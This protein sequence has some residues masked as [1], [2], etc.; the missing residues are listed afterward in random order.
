MV[1]EKEKVFLLADERKDKPFG[2]FFLYC[3]ANMGILGLVYGAIVLG[4]KLSFF[5]A[6][7]VTILG[8]FSYGIVGLM[9]LAGKDTGAVTFVLSRASFGFKG[10]LIPAIAALIGHAGWLSINVCTGTL[11]LLALFLT[12]GV[13]ST[14][15]VMGT[16]LAIF[17]GLVLISVFFSHEMLVKIQTWCTYLFGVLTLVILFVI[18]PK[19]NWAV[20]SAMP[21]GDW[22]GNFLPALAFVMAGT[23]IGWTSYAADYSCHQAP[24]NSSGKVAWAV[25][26]GGVVPLVLMIMVGIL[27]STQVPDLANSANP[28]EVIKGALPAQLA[29][30]YYIT[31]VGGLTPQ[32][33]LGLKSSKL[34]LKAANLILNE[35]MIFIFQALVITIIPI[36]IL[37]VA[38]DFQGTL[39]GFLG[40]I[41]KLLAAWS[42]VFLVD[43]LM[44]RK[45][46]GYSEE[47]LSNPEKNKINYKGVVSW[48]VGFVIGLLFSKTFF[49]N[50][51]FSVG[52]FEGNSLNVLLTLVISGSL[53]FFLNLHNGEESKADISMQ[54]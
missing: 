11:T 8:S 36:Y 10:N 22:L 44:L 9:S 49:F 41:G 39:E 53:Y 40:I 24:T 50:G 43:Y 14:P 54:K 1:A 26:L 38:Q 45:K 47:L 15:M 33:F 28:I 34:V 30:I 18:I 42:S 31:A 32:C 52:I 13:Q 29:I 35:A 2:L 5:Q 4:F 3:A 27:L 23:G 17:I 48:I 51:P 7:L 46:Q 6:V 21:S 37:F 12:L 19:T 20:L 16:S 25:T